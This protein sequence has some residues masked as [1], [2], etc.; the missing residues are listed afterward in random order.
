M[1]KYLPIG[2]ENKTLQEKSMEIFS[3]HILNNYILYNKNT[4]KDT[5]PVTRLDSTAHIRYSARMA[6]RK[7]M[8]NKTDT[9]TASS[10]DGESVY[11]TK[12]PGKT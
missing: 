8:C 5:R 4:S 9:E 3:R 12:F 1:I 7:E 6:P 10:T 11:P 2:T